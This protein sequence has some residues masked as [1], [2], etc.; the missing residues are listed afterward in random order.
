MNNEW[1]DKSNLLRTLKNIPIKIQPG[2]VI[3]GDDGRLSLP[4]YKGAERVLL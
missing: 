3:N 1:A 4:V 2:S